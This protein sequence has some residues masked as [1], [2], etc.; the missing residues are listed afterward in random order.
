[1]YLIY[2]VYTPNK[3]TRE[4][5]NLINSLDKT[6]LET[7]ETLDFEDFIEANE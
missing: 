1:M 5:K 6:N 2:K 7:K 3:L 4:Q